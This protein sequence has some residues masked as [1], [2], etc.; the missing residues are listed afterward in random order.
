[1]PELRFLNYTMWKRLEMRKKKKISTD[2]SK[3]TS[4][5]NSPFSNSGCE[6]KYNPFYLFKTFPLAY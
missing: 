2:K 4:V 3:L 6:L 1:M 5:R